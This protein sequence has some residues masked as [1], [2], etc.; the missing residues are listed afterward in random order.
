MQKQRSVLSYKCRLYLPKHLENNNHLVPDLFDAPQTDREALF[1][2]NGRT[3]YDMVKD[4]CYPDPPDFH[5]ARFKDWF[6]HF[7]PGMFQEGVIK[8]AIKERLSNFMED[9][10]NIVR[11]YCKENHLDLSLFPPPTLTKVQEPKFAFFGPKNTWMDKVDRWL[12][13]TDLPVA[14]AGRIIVWAIR[15][16]T[17]A[18]LL[19]LLIF[20]NLPPTTPLQEQ[21]II[22]AIPIMCLAVVEILIRYFACKSALRRAR[23]EPIIHPVEMRL[24]DVLSNL[25]ELRSK[26]VN[27]MADKLWMPELSNVKTTIR[28]SRPHPDKRIYSISIVS[29][30]VLKPKI[31]FSLIREKISLNIEIIGES[32][33]G[34]HRIFFWFDSQGILT[35]SALRVVNFAKDE[36]CMLLSMLFDSHDKFRGISKYDPEY[37]TLTDPNKDTTLIEYWPIYFPKFVGRLE[38]KSLFRSKHR[39]GN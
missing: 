15:W 34:P 32:V 23:T 20:L 22:L 37:Q 21:L 35:E 17:I 29:E 13:Q 18:V 8:E 24:N 27:Y 7:D 14:R 6:R 30:V 16:T 26:I 3:L 1:L 2:G 5:I 4:H 25:I 33:H 9:R 12:R 19:G 38:W 28:R 39:V 31:F 11:S 10:D 36:I